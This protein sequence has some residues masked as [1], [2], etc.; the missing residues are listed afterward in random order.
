MFRDM[1]GEEGAEGDVSAAQLEEQV[2]E[3]A[4]QAESGETVIMECDEQLSQTCQWEILRALPACIGQDARLCLSNALG[5][6]HQCRACI[7]KV[8]PNA[9]QVK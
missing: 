1:L 3:D 5:D 6:G 7:C 2:Q 4:A 9:C 8:V